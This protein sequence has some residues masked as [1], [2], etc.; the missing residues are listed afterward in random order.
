MGENTW[1]LDDFA[2]GIALGHAAG[3]GCIDAVSVHP[4]PGGA[5]GPCATSKR[6]VD[7]WPGARVL[8]TCV[9]VHLVHYRILL[10]RYVIVAAVDFCADPTQSAGP[11]RGHCAGNPSRPGDAVSRNERAAKPEAPRHLL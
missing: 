11:W 3:P 1:Y 4:H 8:T 2:V 9:L 5:D 7:V 10:Y 6:I